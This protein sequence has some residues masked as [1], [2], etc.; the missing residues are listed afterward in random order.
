MEPRMSYVGFVT[1]WLCASSSGGEFDS[2]PA[3][4]LLVEVTFECGLWHN[5]LLAVGTFTFTASL[6]LWKCIACSWNAFNC[7]CCSVNGFGGR[8]VFLEAVQDEILMKL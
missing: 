3:S 2:R 7:L 8:G 4:V 5:V 1:V 6:R